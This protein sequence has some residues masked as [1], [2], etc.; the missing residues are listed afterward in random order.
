MSPKLLNT[1]LILLSFALYYIVIN[2][3]WTGSGSVWSPEHSIIELRDTYSQYNYTVGQA[4]E[5]FSQGKQLNSQYKS[6]DEATQ[7]KMLQMVPAFVDPIRLLSEITNIA[8]QS[9]LALSGVSYTESAPNDKMYG[10]YDISFSVKTTYSK[11]K[12]L[13]HSYETSLRLYTV[14]SVNFTAPEKV[15]DLILFQVKLR[16]YYLK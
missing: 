8:N 10:A 11:F 15:D 7:Q 2:P 6:I 5:L 3:L 16:T 9:G 13:M 14:Q 1:F 4:S 12:E